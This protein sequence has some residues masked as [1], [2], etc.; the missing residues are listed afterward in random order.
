LAARARPWAAR[1]RLFGLI[2]T[3]NGALRAPPARRSFAVSYSTP[4]NIYKI[5][6]TWAAHVKGFFFSLDHRGYQIGGPLSPAPPIA[7]SL[8][9]PAIFLGSQSCL[10]APSFFLQLC[11]SSVSSVDH[12]LFKVVRLGKMERTNKTSALIFLVFSFFNSFWIFFCNSLLFLL[13]F[14]TSSYSSL[15]FS[16]DS[17]C[18]Y[19][20]SSSYSSLL[21]F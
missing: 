16:S 20:S 2:D 3:P 1:T 6:R 11:V 4:K 21:I 12:L 14:S 10:G 5:Y 18:N 9:L 15:L 7:A 17:S 13:S 19:Y 8:I